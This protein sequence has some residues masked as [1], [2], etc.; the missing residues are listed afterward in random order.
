MSESGS[1]NVADKIKDSFSS[2]KNMNDSTAVYIIIGVVIMIALIALMVYFY[3]TGTIFSD[4]LRAR[5]CS[6]MNTIYST[7]NGKISSIDPNNP[8]Y[9]YSFRDYY[10]KTAYNA[11]SGGKYKNDYVDICVL[12]DLIKQGV[13][14][15][16]FEIYSLDDQPI[17]ATSTSDNYHVKETFNSVLFSDVMSTIRDYAFINSTTPNPLDPIIIHLRIKTTN[18]NMYKNLAKILEGYTGLLLDKQYS[19]ENQGKNLGAVKLSDLTGKIV[20]IVDRSNNS[21]LESPEFHEFIN[22]TSHSIF[23]KGLNYYDIM[24]TENSDE[25][26]EYNKLNMTIGMPDK[27][28]NPDNPS[29]ATMRAN[30]CQLLALR[31]QNID[32]NLEENALFFNEQGHAFVLKPEKLRY[33]PE[34]IPEPEPQDPKLSYA[35]REVKSDFYN[36]EI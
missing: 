16:D 33:V 35:T 27:G 10:V 34:T 15:L 8:E 24:Y 18:Q 5:Q 4:G 7:V 13:R 28:S 25:L 21:F 12:K 29:G 11:C 32:T 6:F 30:G 19:F 9:Q 23:M 22:M 1:T 3:Y 31:Y 36:F 26:I 20:I 17:V 14:G 2:I